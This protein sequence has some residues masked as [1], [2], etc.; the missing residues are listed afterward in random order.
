MTPLHANGE[1]GRYPGSLYADQVTPLEP[2]PPLRGRV[3]AEVCVVGGGI[4]GLSAALHLARAGRRVVVLEAQRVG[5]GACGRNGGQVG[6]GLNWS[7]GRL[8]ERLGAG[9]ADALWR[10]AEDAKADARAAMAEHASE[11]RYRPGI[12][13][14]ALTADELAAR[15]ESAAWI[16]DRYGAPL[17]VLDRDALAARIGTDAYAGGVL[18]P[19]AGV[20][21]PLAYAL[22]LARAARAAGAAIHE[23]SEVHRIRP[24]HAATGQGSV[25]A[26]WIVHAT[27]GYSPHLT[28]AKAARVLPINNYI[29]ATGPLD[30]PVMPDPV[31]VADSRFVVNY[32]H[33]TPDGRLVYGGGESYG[34]RFPRDIRAKVRDNLRRAYPGLADAPLPHAWGGTLAVTATRLPYLAEAAPRVI[35]AGGYSGHGLALAGLIGRI[36]AE[37][38]GGDRTRLDLVARLPVPALPGGR[39]LGGAMTTATMA[40]FALR[41]RLRHGA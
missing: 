24:G 10:L 25:D 28:R 38:I 40:A 8:I 23:G 9:A 17:A 2:F 21:N 16:A 39:W 19:T 35:A 41:D 3:E 27:N 31:A 34:R 33:Q 22:G 1:R 14:A 29:A 7:Q 13:S 32:F 18:D 30:P 12:V 5:W 11:A 15:A 26:E 4:T 36:A 20:C 6:S 37:A